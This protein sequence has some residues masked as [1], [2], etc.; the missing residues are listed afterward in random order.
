MPQPLSATAMRR[1]AAYL[2]M[3][4]SALAEQRP[5]PAEQGEHQERVGEEGQRRGGRQELLAEEDADRDEG[6]ESRADQSGDADRH[7]E[8]PG[9]TGHEQRQRP[10][11]QARG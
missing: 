5:A 10:Q 9:N 8:K 4:S 6:E 1:I 2:A 3:R 7:G 11:G